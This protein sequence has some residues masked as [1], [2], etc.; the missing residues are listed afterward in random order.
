MEN[1]NFTYG[2]KYNDLTN[3]GHY[4]QLVWSATHKVGCGFAQCRRPYIGKPYF[5]YVCNY[6][7]M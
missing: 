2:S 6:C 4:T 5:S 1:K 3:V 7:P